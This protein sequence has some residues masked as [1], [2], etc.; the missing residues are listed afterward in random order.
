MFLAPVSDFVMTHGSVINRPPSSGQHCRT[1]NFV[2]STLSPVR[3]T[4]WHGGVL[5]LTIFGGNFVIRKRVGSMAIFSLSRSGA[6]ICM[7][8]STSLA[9]F[10]MS[11]VPSAIAILF[12]LPNAL[13]S[14]G[15]VAP[16][17]FSKSRALPPPGDLLTRSVIS[18]ISRIGET[19]SVMRISSPS[20]SSSA[21]KSPSESNEFLSVS[22]KG[23]SFISN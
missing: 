6:F 14:T 3:I 21:I 18:V 4:S 22:P 12:W 10:S 11:S 1:G 17:T 13:I 23:L 9:I 5:S 20:R 16:S 15:A 2:K 8:D 7:S 19:S